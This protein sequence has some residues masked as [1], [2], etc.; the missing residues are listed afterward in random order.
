MFHFMYILPF[1]ML[2]LPRKK[3]ISK[4]TVIILFL[5]ASQLGTVLMLVMV[6]LGNNFFV[7]ASLVD[8]YIT[9]S[10]GV[11]YQWNIYNIILFSINSSTFVYLCFYFYKNFTS[12]EWSNYL[13]YLTCLV[14][15]F[16][17]FQA[18]L[19]RYIICSTIFLGIYYIYNLNNK[20]SNLILI[21][22]L[23]LQFVQ[24][25]VLQKAFKHSECSDI[26]YSSIYGIMNHTCSEKKINQYIY[27]DGTLVK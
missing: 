25:F 21:S 9:G 19:E 27:N 1:V 4:K 20:L 2:F 7:F 8:S 18:P 23:S 17:P 3:K 24:P 16:I 5:M 12:T 10:Y 11:N 26:M 22:L 6:Y 14:A 13:A 15:V